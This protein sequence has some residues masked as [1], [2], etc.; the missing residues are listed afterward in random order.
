MPGLSQK[1]HVFPK[2][3]IRRFCG[4]HNGAQNVVAIFNIREVTPAERNSNV[5]TPFYRGPDDGTFLANW[6][7]DKL[8]ERDPALRA[9]A[10]D[11]FTEHQ[12]EFPTE[13][14]RQAGKSDSI[15]GRY[16]NL[17][18]VLE[19]P[20]RNHVF[21][22]LNAEE[23]K[24]VSD[25]YFLWQAR[26]ALRD[27]DQ[28]PI[29]LVGIKTDVTVTNSPEMLQALGLPPTASREDVID[30]FERRGVITAHDTASDG[31]A[32]TSARQMYGAQIQ[33]CV[34]HL[35]L[36]WGNIRRI[37]C[38]LPDANLVVPDQFEMFPYVPLSPTRIFIPK[39]NQPLVPVYP[40]F[41]RANCEKLL[42]LVESDPRAAAGMLNNA[43]R[44]QSK[45]YYFQRP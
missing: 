15:E 30:E 2:D 10:W 38:T 20:Q 45:S 31:N 8:G 26:A 28:T 40:R 16:H 21:E 39:E 25:F 5:P 11:D 9:G 17:S 4:S 32:A 43:A 18:K 7:E 35:G 14:E 36:K 33:L 24:V 3:A 12:N 44:A 19:S 34:R 22:D 41:H 6:H 37:C 29:G 13:A 42:G 27:A 23:S 1:Q